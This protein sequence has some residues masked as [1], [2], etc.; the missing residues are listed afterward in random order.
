MTKL[1][2]TIKQFEMPILNDPVPDLIAT[3][4]SREECDVLVDIYL[5]THER[6]YRVLHRPTF[7]QYYDAFWQDPAASSTP[8]RMTLI[9]ILALGTTLRDDAGECALASRKVRTW[10]YAAQWWLTG[11]TEKTTF[12]LEGMQVACLLQLARQMTVVGRAWASSGTLLQ[13]A[14]ATGLHRDPGHFPAMAPRQ[15]QLQRQLWATVRELSLLSAMDSPMQAYV[16]L[17]ACDT[18]PPEN[19]DDVDVGTN[20]EV[21]G[22][23]RPD[24]EMTDASL[25]R[26][27]CKSFSSRLQAAKLIHGSGD[28]VYADAISLANTL[29]AA[30]SELSQ[31]FDTHSESPLLNG[32]HSGF[33]DIHFRLH[34]LRLHRQFLLQKSDETSCFLSRKVC[35]DAATVIASYASHNT[36]PDVHLRRLSRLFLS[37]TG[38][39]RAPFSL[40]IITM[41]GLELRMQLVDDDTHGRGP[42]GA[43]ARAAREPIFETLARIRGEF[44]RRIEHGS[45]QCKPYGLAMSI[46]A[47]LR[48]V[49]RR[50]NPEQ[51]LSDAVTDNLA[52]V[53]RYMEGTVDR[54]TASGDAGVGDLDL[55]A[56]LAMDFN[57]YGGGLNFGGFGMEDEMWQ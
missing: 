17:A 22:C 45:P 39:M 9:L 14:F 56:L 31:F 4:P 28:I 26:L 19:I 18:K 33:L 53:T 51:A 49:E 7:A 41:L 16:D 6:I 40:E 35:F 27:L 10:L 36:S 25:Q 1:R 5:S 47:Q 12:T 20:A 21:P 30:C 38:A 48:A 29:K 54:L 50:E 43:L 2:L 23:S 13:M 24:E 52:E 3:L 44:L 55:D 32:F 11:P 57:R 15:A 37:T 34:I 42:A 8:F 46:L